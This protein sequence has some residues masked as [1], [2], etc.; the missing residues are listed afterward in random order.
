M[1]LDAGH[2]AVHNG[3]TMH[4]ANGNEKNLTKRKKKRKGANDGNDNHN[5]VP[6]F[7]TRY[8]IAISYVDSHAE[9]RHNIPGVGRNVNRN[10]ARGQSNNLAFLGDAEDRSSY[11]EW[12]GDV[13][14]RSRFKRAIGSSMT[15]SLMFGHHHRSNRI[16]LWCDNLSKLYFNYIKHY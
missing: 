7:Q 10:N 2:C 15:F 3:W 14:P 4:C 1:P 9:V 16:Q 13:L 12:I 6:A 11:A 5:T 8:A